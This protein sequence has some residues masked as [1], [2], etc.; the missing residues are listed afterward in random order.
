MI[1]VFRR[2]FL[3]VKEPNKDLIHEMRNFKQVKINTDVF[4]KL[5]E[6]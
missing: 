3:L 4:E 2:T 5:N 1:P 6:K